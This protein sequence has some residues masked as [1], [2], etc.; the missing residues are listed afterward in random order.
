[1]PCLLILTAAYLHNLL[2]T[3]HTTGLPL[4][5]WIFFRAL[6][7]SITNSNISFIESSACLKSFVIF[8]QLHN[9]AEFCRISLWHINNFTHLQDLPEIVL[10]SAQ[11]FPWDLD[12]VKYLS[13]PF[14]SFNKH[15]S[16]AYVAGTRLPAGAI[17]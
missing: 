15:L 10:V 5:S 1:M 7:D 9:K 8:S 12:F 3:L 4:V 14:T 13:I 6:V 17:K 11:I 2:K 16:N